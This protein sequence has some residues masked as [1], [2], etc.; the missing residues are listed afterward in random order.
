VVHETGHDGPWGI[1]PICSTEVADTNRRLCWRSASRSRTA[2]VSSAIGGAVRCAEGDLVGLSSQFGS[3][4]GEIFSVGLEL[5]DDVFRISGEAI[6]GV[7]G[8]VRIRPGRIQS[9]PFLGGQDRS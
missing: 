9:K 7:I 2:S 8:V 1:S 5:G 4:A 6:D 3:F